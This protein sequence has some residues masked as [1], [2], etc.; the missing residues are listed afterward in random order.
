MC[1]VKQACFLEINKLS[2]E[3]QDKIFDDNKRERLSMSD[4]KIYILE[5]LFHALTESMICLNNTYI[6]DDMEDLSLIEE[7]R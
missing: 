7:E 6:F 5:K 2:E 3:E 4:G 1:G